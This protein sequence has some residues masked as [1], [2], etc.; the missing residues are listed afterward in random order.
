[1]KMHAVVLPIAGASLLLCMAGCSGKPEGQTG[2]APGQKVESRQETGSVPGKA[3]AV[4]MTPGLWEITSKMEMKNM[5][6]AI[7]PTTF[8]QCLTESD[9][10]PKSDATASDCRISN[11]KVQGDTVSYAME[12]LADGNKTVSNGTLTYRGTTMEG[13]MQF[14]VSGEQ[15]AQM[16]TTF[17]GK[18]LGPCKP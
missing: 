18:R 16:T 3:A 1:M 8:T 15:Q 12:C 7:P 17:S 13:S 4:N 5:P 6:F 9:L 11:L 2:V 14:E 10:V